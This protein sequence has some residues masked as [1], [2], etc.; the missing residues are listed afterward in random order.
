M[1]ISAGWGSR[2]DWPVELLQTVSGVE[3]PTAGPFCPLLHSLL[4]LAWLDWFVFL[5][6]RER[7]RQ[8][9]DNPIYGFAIYYKFAWLLGPL[10]HRSADGLLS[11]LLMSRCRAG[12]IIAGLIHV[13]G[14][15][16]SHP[17]CWFAA[18]RME[19]KRTSQN[20]QLALSSLNGSVI[21]ANVTPLI[22]AGLLRLSQIVVTKAPLHVM[23]AQIIHHTSSP[24]AKHHKM[25]TGSLSNRY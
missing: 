19:K 3:P 17:D 1:N 25:E 2:A 11:W 14:H 15:P 8:A 22:N 6:Q 4:F 7:G 16:R 23:G 5:E 13:L 21:F 9:V 24:S 12:C 20:T 10:S 18:E